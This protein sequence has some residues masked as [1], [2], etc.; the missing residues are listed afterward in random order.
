MD[1]VDADLIDRFI[2]DLKSPAAFD[3]KETS[4]MLDTSKID[5]YTARYG[6]GWR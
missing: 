2:E 1:S 6:M 4:T 3:N 5:A